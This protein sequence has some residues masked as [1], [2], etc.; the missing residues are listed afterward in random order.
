MKTTRLIFVDLPAH[1]HLLL[2]P[3][4]A[5]KVAGDNRVQEVTL[6]RSNAERAID[7]M[8]YRREGLRT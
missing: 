1:L 7:R 2:G 5:R 6:V 3:I 4:L 8:A